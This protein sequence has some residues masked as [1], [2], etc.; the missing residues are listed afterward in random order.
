MIDRAS[1][2]PRNM[3]RTA[4]G[5]GALFMAHLDEKKPAPSLARAFQSRAVDPQNS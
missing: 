3:R 1:V 2:T 5:T 4:G